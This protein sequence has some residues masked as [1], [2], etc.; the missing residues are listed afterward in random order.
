ME[1]SILALIER[2]YTSGTDEHGNRVMIPIVR[3]TLKGDY[4]SRDG[5]TYRFDGTS[6][7]RV[8]PTV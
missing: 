3:R 1:A 2:G 6:L 7:R 4:T 5:R 8:T